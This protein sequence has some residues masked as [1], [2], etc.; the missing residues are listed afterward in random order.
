MRVCVNLLGAEQWFGGDLDG[1]INLVRLAE[2]RGV[3]QVVLPEHVAFGDDLGGYPFGEFLGAR[4]SPWYE[5]IVL[6]AGIATATESIRLATGVLI[7]PLRPAVLLAKQ[8]TTLDILSKGRLDIGVGTGWHKAEFDA[9][10]VSFDDRI[11]QLD[12]QVRACRALWKTAPASFEGKYIRFSG[13]Y[14]RPAPRQAGGVPIW[15]GVPPSAANFARIAEIGNGWL[16]MG[17]SAEKLAENVTKLRKAF[18]ARGRDPSTVGI[19]HVLMPASGVKSNADLASTLLEAKGWVDAGAN[20]IE[21]YPQMFCQRLEQF[22]D[23]LDGLLSL[24]KMDRCR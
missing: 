3:D 23:F 16:P 11:G 22:E 6:L 19:R 20:I 24:K 7:A 8:L 18:V 17:L 1:M 4:D 15:F 9:C 5:P 21:M 13:L 10:G 2:R 14:Q 12:E